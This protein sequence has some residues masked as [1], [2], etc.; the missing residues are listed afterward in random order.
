LTDRDPSPAEVIEVL[1]ATREQ[2]PILGNLLELY[3]YDFSAFH[4]LQLGEDGRF[5]YRD[6]PLYWHEESRSPFLVRVDGELAGLAL[7]R[8]GSRISEDKN[9]WDMAE[10]FIVR[11]CR[12]RG[13]GRCAAHQI[14]RRFPG[15]WE[16]RVMESNLP[17]LRF[18]EQAARSF[19][20]GRL[21]LSRFEENGQ[22]W[23]L[24]AFDS[25]AV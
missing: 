20:G 25:S 19:A 13:V 7:V 2:Q 23:R 10:F 21:V 14:W 15:P 12:R 17:A 4:P 5:G 11:G 18:W 1:A 3:A 22:P 8:R 24:F 16:I 6:L 9:V